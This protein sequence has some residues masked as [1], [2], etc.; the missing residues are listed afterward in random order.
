MDKKQFQLEYNIHSSAKILYNRLS[1]PSG[2]SEWFAD[3]VNIENN[4]IFIF[5][6]EGN[7]IKAEVLSKKEPFFIRYKWLDEDADED[8]FFEFKIL[9]DE[10]TG[11]SALV[12]T[13]FA[14]PDEI[15]DSIQL[16]DTQIE[17]LKHVLG[18]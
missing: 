8:I 13:D 6:W 16:W 2:L 15:K 3:N 9:I 7:P 17:K 10:L 14:E 12:I 1:T 11:D 18:S 4:N 5:I